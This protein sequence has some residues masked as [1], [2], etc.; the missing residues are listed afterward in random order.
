MLHTGIAGVL[1]FFLFACVLLDGA[2]GVPINLKC[3]T[4]L[5]CDNLNL[6]KP[7]PCFTG[8]FDAALACARIFEPRPD[9]HRST[10]A[11]LLTGLDNY[12]LRQIV[13][14]SGP[15]FNVA[16]DV[17]AALNA[18]LE[19]TYTAEIEF[20]E[21]VQS[22]LT[23]LHDA[24]TSY[25][26]KPDCFGQALAVSPFVFDI[27]IADTAPTAGGQQNA[28]LPGA[29]FVR[30]TLARSSLFDQYTATFPDRASAMHDAIGR[31]VALIDGLETITALSAWGD[32]SVG[33]A[34]DAS[35]R[36]NDAVRSFLYRQ[37]SV[38][39]WPSSKVIEFTLDDAATGPTL[40]MP[41]MI[42]YMRNFGSP[43]W[44]A[45]PFQLPATL[46]TQLHLPRFSESVSQKLQ[47]E[48]AFASFHS[49]HSQFAS[50][51]AFLSSSSFSS[52]SSTSSSSRLIIVP[53]GST[54]SGIA[55]FVQTTAASK[56]ARR[57]LVLL[58][59]SFSIAPESAEYTEFFAV[60]AQCLS[61]VGP[62]DAI[63][64]DV[65]SNGGGLVL[66]GYALLAMVFPQFA[67]STATVSSTA[68]RYLYDEPQSVAAA[69]IAAR[70]YQCLTCGIDPTT[71]QTPP[72]GKWLFDPPVAW[73]QGGVRG[74][75]SKQFLMDTRE[76]LA[77]IAKLKYPK[78]TVTDRARVTI[79]TDG[80]C[81]S[82][83]CLFATLAR[84]ANAATFVGVGGL[85]GEPIDVAS[86]CGGYVNNLG[87][88]ATVARYLGTGIRVPQFPTTAK[89]QWNQGVLYSRARPSL[90]MQFVPAPA[91]V[92]MPFWAFPH[93]SVPVSASEARRSEL[94][95]AVVADALTRWSPA[96]GDDDTVANGYR[97]ATITLGVT[98]GLISIAAAFA[99]VVVARRKA[100][101]APLLPSGAGEGE[102]GLDSVATLSSAESGSGGAPHYIAMSSGQ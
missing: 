81:G 96:P 94:W 59:P 41:W 8:D 76:A 34:N 87:Q 10:I 60:A 64:I 47:V 6:P 42:G 56:A 24:H 21:D 35:A 16:V 91:D 82:T 99:C 97:T 5:Y 65:Q 18:T 67:P 52:S 44:C 31:T 77:T 28:G 45:A 63:V 51:S 25:Y 39:R 32:S 43:F 29:S 7:L 71:L 13:R 55:C 49:S 3:P 48:D 80:L 2:N 79:L 17:I 15:P 40:T 33:H 68:S 84:E 101:G 102:S 20:H 12:G 1:A 74:M 9:W 72:S 95:D 90:P 23:E 54:A 89:W 38:Q 93:P 73:V 92:R 100:Q 62:R 78:P 61:A 88:L 66:A 19:R 75:H 30:V 27:T 58:V 26:S 69:A 46:P 14:Q 70:D 36:F 98:M 4:L 37:L 50:A 22:A 57:T 11:A 85:W 83:C 53:P 86:F